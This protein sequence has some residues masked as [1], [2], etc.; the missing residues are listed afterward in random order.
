MKDE[1]YRVIKVGNEDGRRVGGYRNATKLYNSLAGARGQVG[2]ERK[3]VERRNSWAGSL[4]R[5]KQPLPEF[6]IQKS[7]LVWEDVE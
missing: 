7:A 6:K 1:V 4:G 5:E 2:R 3:A